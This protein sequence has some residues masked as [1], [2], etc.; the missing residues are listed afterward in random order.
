MSDSSL[1]RAVAF[2]IT[3]GQLSASITAMMAVAFLPVK[4]YLDVES[5]KEEQ[6]KM[7]VQQ[8]EMQVQQVKMNADMVC[9]QKD[10]SSILAKV[11]QRRGWFS[12]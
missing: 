10:V 8:A 9:I 1:K 7:Q 2:I 4:T 12:W 3:G 6:K 5:I 11:S